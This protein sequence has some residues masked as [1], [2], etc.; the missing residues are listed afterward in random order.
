M[1]NAEYPRFNLYALFEKRI[2]FCNAPF[3]ANTDFEA[4]NAIRNFVFSDKTS[5]IAVQPAEF[6]LIKIGV[7][8]S[9]T[10]VIEPCHFPVCLVSDLVGG[11]SDAESV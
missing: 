5:V 11:V 1:I 6:E 8:D 9:Q 10:G 7:V 2:S 3:V 4:M